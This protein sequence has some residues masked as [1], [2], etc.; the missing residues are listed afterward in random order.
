MSKEGM[1]LIV[2]AGG[3]ASGRHSF[4]RNFRHSFAL[5][6]SLRSLEEGLKKK[7]SFVTIASLNNEEID[8]LKQAA[9]SGY[10]LTL[11]YLFTGSTLALYRAHSRSIIEKKV[12]SKTNVLSS[13]SFTYKGLAKSLPYFDLVFFLKNYKELEFI[14]AYEPQ[15]TEEEV[16]ARTILALKR[17]AEG[18]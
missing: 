5:D 11:Y 16:L 18:E 10:R 13:Y 15:K 6:F 4:L 3:E 14:S 7:E 1:Q 17:E 9:T 12:F 2:I 8:L